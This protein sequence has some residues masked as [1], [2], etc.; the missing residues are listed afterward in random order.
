MNNH[1]PPHDLESE[2][3]V[4]GA[5]LLNPD[6]LVPVIDILEDNADMFSTA[7]HQHLYECIVHVFENKNPVDAITIRNELDRRGYTEASGGLRY[8]TE[9]TG[10][11]PTSANCAQY[12]R[13]VRDHAIMRRIAEV[14]QWAIQQAHACPED[15]YA[16][17]EEIQTKYGAL[18]Q[19][20]ED[21]LTHVSQITQEFSDTVRRIAS[22]EIPPGLPTGLAGLDNLTGGLRAGDYFVIAA[23]TSV[24]KT[25]LAM[26]IARNVMAADTEAS[27]VMFS[28]EMGKEALLKRLCNSIGQVNFHYLDRQEDVDENLAKMDSALSLIDKSGLYID[29]TSHPT[30]QHISSKLRKYKTVHGCPDLIIVDY[31]QLLTTHGKSSR[32]EEL[33]IISRT[34][35]GLAMEMK[36]PIIV[37]SQFNRKSVN[38][39]PSISELRDSGSIEQDSDLILILHPDAKEYDILNGYLDKSRNGPTGHFLLRFTKKYQLIESINNETYDKPKPED[40]DNEEWMF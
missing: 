3:A 27:V 31:I 14:G 39:R 19:V 38:D 36:C 16:L 8:I 6:A 40:K 30:I 35:K 12:A 10:S 7:A 1:T 33:N 32:N 13:I 15:V 11:V 34:L 5:M 26:N 2:K 25:A 9:L 28:M 37:L 24:G 23:K 20:P 21:T 17:T 4:I 22:G 18:S 29:E